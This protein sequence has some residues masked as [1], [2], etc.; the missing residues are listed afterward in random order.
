MS[1]K[2]CL[3]L[4]SLAMLITSAAA[5]SDLIMGTWADN[6]YPLV[7]SDLRLYCYAHD[8]LNKGPLDLNFLTSDEIEVPASNHTIYETKYFE[9]NDTTFVTALIK[10]LTLDD[11]KKFGIK[12]CRYNKRS[13]SH[14]IYFFI[15][16][17]NGAPNITVNKDKLTAELGSSLTMSCKVSVV[18][19]DPVIGI[20]LVWKYGTNTGQL[21]NG[22]DVSLDTH[23]VINPDKN[24]SYAESSLTIS[25]VRGYHGGKYFCVA[26]LPLTTPGR[27]AHFNKVVDL[28][29]VVNSAQSK[30]IEMKVKAGESNTFDCSDLVVYP[31]P[32]L[33]WKKD[34]AE[35]TDKTDNRYTFSPKKKGEP[36]NLKFTIKDVTYSDRSEYSCISKVVNSTQEKQFRL[37]VRD[38][39]GALW[40]FIGILAETVL[41]II[42][43]VI[44]ELYK[45]KYHSSKDKTDGGLKE[46]SPLVGSTSPPVVSYTTGEGVRARVTSGDEE[47]TA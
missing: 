20:N 27:I 23:V 32:V 33:S 13:N 16:P 15:I 14:V 38:P 3:C 19:A 6:E 43:I 34:G 12:K 22:T 8:K 9:K 26:E 4:F 18:L 37:R 44:Y 46:T 21:P 17:E 11:G 5:I 41:L 40:P 2:L 10:N 1:R 24:I 29:A 28:M 7:G 31:I 39:L 45:K 36:A 30:E 42:I 47:N 35:I 25:H